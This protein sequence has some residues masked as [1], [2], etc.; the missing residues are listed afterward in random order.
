MDE[1][2]TILEKEFNIKH[3]SDE[4]KWKKALW[5]DGYNKSQEQFGNSDEQLILNI[6]IS[7]LK[8]DI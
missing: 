4:T 8:L 5:K 7:N 2:D 6:Y 3:P 1:V